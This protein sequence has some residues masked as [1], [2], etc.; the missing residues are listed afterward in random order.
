MKQGKITLGVIIGNRDFFPDVLV[1][2]ARQDILKVLSEM[3]IDAVILSETDT[4]LGGVETWEDAKKCAA[5]FKANQDKIDGILVVLPNFGDEKGVADT[6]KLSGLDVPI[7]VQAYPDDLDGFH[8]ERRRDAFC[9]KI[10]VCNNL[11]QYGFPF[12]LTELH[13]VYPTSDEFKA[14][15]QKFVGVCRVVKGLR[16][17]RLGAVGARPN[18]FN[19]VRFSEK[20]LQAYGITVST[21]D[22]SEV[23]GAADKLAD[24][25]PKVKQRL[26]EI[27]EYLPTEGV[28]SV[29]LV[30][31]AKLGIVIDD[32]MAANDL[33]ATAIQCWTS[34]QQ[35]YG[36]NVCTLMSMMSE[37]LM[38][39]ACEVDIT[40]VASM[41][42]LQL[43]SGKPSALV[44]WNNN[45]GGDP[46]KC[47]LFHCGNW[48]RSFFPEAKMAYADVLAT[49][50][51]KENTYGAIAGRV[52]AGPMSFARITT[53]DRNGV[54]RTYVGDGTFTDDPLDTFGSRA[55]VEV[56]G[57][58][59]LL[60]H[61]CKNGFE[62]HVA[63]N[64]SHS[65]AILAEAFETY[66]GWEVYYHKG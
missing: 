37:K 31:M 52:P 45:Y 1:T 6:I 64:P 32:W 10:S 58:Q 15:L 66:F 38:P 34:V 21:I 13:T 56:P 33:D 48:A 55:V 27:Q 19:T 60:Q 42:A 57:L 49:T 65:A 2:E 35:N 54:I 12:T 17:A 44:D 53:D 62:H 3:S 26:E 59:K 63:M 61:I 16:N 41:Y 51:G 8:V 23:F 29:A 18:A 25:D 22:L 4:K 5:L 28:P 47:V 39:S 30:K 14:D 46:N 20:L 43:A 24:D 11:R 40:G 50:L 9:G 7:L 36:V